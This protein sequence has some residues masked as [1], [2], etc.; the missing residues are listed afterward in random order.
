MR[1]LKITLLSF[2]VFFLGGCRSYTDEAVLKQN[3][4]ELLAKYQ[5]GV[6]DM[7]RDLLESVISDRFSFYTVDRERYI[8]ELLIMTMLVDK[9]TYANIRVENYKIFADITTQGSRIFKPGVQLPLFKSLPFMN[10]RLHKQSVMTFLYEEKDGLKILAEDQIL[11]EQEILW[12][13]H[14]PS[15]IQPRLSAYRAAPG[16]QLAVSFQVNKSGNDVLFVFVNEHLLGGYSLEGYN[17]EMVNYT[18]KI[19]ADLKRGDD[20]EIKLMAFAGK[21]DLNN[22]GEAVLQGATVRSYIV[23]VR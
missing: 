1:F 6:N 4:G 8:E 12:G 11:T 5:R 22:P 7:N 18:V 10:G 13:T 3:I 9:I 20:F 17:G 23:P 21:I 14:P 19:P 15:I 16:D 2:L